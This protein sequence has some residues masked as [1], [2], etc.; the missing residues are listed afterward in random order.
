MRNW[1]KSTRTNRWRDMTAGSFMDEE[2]QDNI[3]PII[4]KDRAKWPK[5]EFP[6][7]GSPM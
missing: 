7:H 2:V 5:P 3:V 4:L 1:R 6:D